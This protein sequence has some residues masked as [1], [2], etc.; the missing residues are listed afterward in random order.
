MHHALHTLFDFDKG[1]V[2]NEVDDLAADAGTDRV[3]AFDVV[4]RVRHA[5]LEAERNA[6]LIAIN[7]QNHYF[8]FLANLHNF[9]GWL[10]APA[11]IGDMKQSVHAVEINECTEVGDI[12]DHTTAGFANLDVGK[13][14]LFLLAT[15][16]F[17]QLAA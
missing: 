1:A 9:R 14:Y 6:I 12:L 4:P 3:L 2:G 7:V 16:F 15:T 5:L 13:Q 8:D 10:N 11:H 17:H